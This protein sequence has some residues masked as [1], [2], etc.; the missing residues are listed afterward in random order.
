MKLARF[1]KAVR[2]LTRVVFLIWGVG[3]ILAMVLLIIY[4]VGMRSL[5]NKP[6]MSSYE[7][8]MFL[9]SIVVFTAF[10]YTQSE[11]NIVRIELVVSRFPRKIQTILEI[12][13]SILSLGLSVLI[14]WQC[15][16]R[17]IGLRQEH[18]VSPILSIPVY[19]FYLVGAL[20]FALLSLV[21]ISDILESVYG[22]ERHK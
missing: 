4:D 18:L 7:L 20:G 21:L 13:M 10:G 5:F 11:R 19:P 15:F 9:M 17:A 12:I 3:G 16:I 8:T 2:S 14:S 22:I 1:S 6:M